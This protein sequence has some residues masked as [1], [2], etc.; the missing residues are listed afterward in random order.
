MAVNEKNRNLI[1]G[2]V[3]VSS[4]KGYYNYVPEQLSLISS[5]K[6]KKYRIGDTV[7]IKVVA[8][9]KNIPA[10]DFEVA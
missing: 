10:I 4:L 6:R 3:H 2:L 7:K 8:A 1:E 9:N 5:D